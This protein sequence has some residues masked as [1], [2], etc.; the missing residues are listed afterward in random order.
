VQDLVYSKLL[1][2]FF[3]GIGMLTGLIMLIAPA[4]VGQASRRLGNWYSGSAMA[5][6]METPYFIERLFYRHH[7]VFGMLVSVAALWS[8]SYL[9]RMLEHRP[10]LLSLFKGIPG[11]L[12]AILLDTGIVFLILG[13]SF[14]AAV[15][16]VVFI[17]P[18]ILK[19]L[20]G[21]ANQWV[22]SRKWLESFVD[23]GHPTANAAPRLLGVFIL[24][25]SLFGF[26]QWFL[27]GYIKF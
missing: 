15:G 3:T 4:D 18:S 13:T 7:R 2:P 27:Y 26:I 9:V 6:L 16:V 22:Q 20:E 11:P 12:A 10:E 24:L 23:Q 5:R 8:L 14:A 17:R 19:G 1:L 25:F 21:K